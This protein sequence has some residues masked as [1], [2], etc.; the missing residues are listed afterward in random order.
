L[1]TLLA[2]DTLRK[3]NTKKDFSRSRINTFPQKVGE[4]TH[5]DSI[6]GTSMKSVVDSGSYIIQSNT[7]SAMQLSSDYL[8]DLIERDLG[9]TLD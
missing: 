1:E 9:I 5:H 6:T 8:K 3:G 2:L 7:T 4:L